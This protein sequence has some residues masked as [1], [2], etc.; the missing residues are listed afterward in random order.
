MCEGP[1][2]GL[3]E[4]R[5]RASNLDQG[6]AQESEVTCTTVY[7]LVLARRPSKTG[8]LAEWTCEAS[9]VEYKSAFHPSVRMCSLGARTAAST[10]TERLTLGIRTLCTVRC[11]RAVAVLLGRTPRSTHPGSWP[12]RSRRGWPPPPSCPWAAPRRT[13]GA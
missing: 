12:R 6:G 4:G 3:Y 13:Q 9:C 10:A 1:C 11:H 7:R 5:S 2:E 8:V